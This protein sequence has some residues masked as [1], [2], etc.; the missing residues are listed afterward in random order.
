M[1]GKKI[2]VAEE[3]DKE[4]SLNEQFEENKKMDRVEKVLAMFSKDK[5]VL[6]EE[7]K[8]NYLNQLE[9]F[10]N[11]YA[12]ETLLELKRSGSTLKSLL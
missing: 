5:K 1:S 10:V 12:T 9:L 7:L 11:Q 2:V 8:I 3:K 6:S 4:P